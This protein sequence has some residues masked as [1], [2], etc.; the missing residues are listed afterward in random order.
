MKYTD[1]MVDLETTGTLPD[2][3]G[4][5][6]IAA[7]KFN[8]ET[9]EVDTEFFDRC[10]WLPKWRSWDEGTRTWWGQQRPDILRGIMVRQEDPHVVMREFVEWVGERNQLRFWS[11]PTHFD[12]MFLSSYCNDLGVTNPFDFR[13]ATD[14]RSYMRGLYAPEPLQELSVPFIGDAHNALYDTLH[15]IQ[16]L[17]AHC[18]DARPKVIEEAA[19]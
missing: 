16:V 5:I 10:L 8:L 2:R 6:Q 13:E 19:E 3:A 11:K 15:Q 4:I 14:L 7:I 1:C 18:D 17:F 12:F 9:R